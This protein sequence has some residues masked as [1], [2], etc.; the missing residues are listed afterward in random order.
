VDLSNEGVGT[1]LRKQP[2]V[3][4]DFTLDESDTG[5]TGVTGNHIRDKKLSDGRCA[6][7]V[8][9]AAEKHKGHFDMRFRPV[10]GLVVANPKACWP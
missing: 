10:P 9:R 6:R 3:G 8:I 7:D 5:I 2:A 4:I 1:C